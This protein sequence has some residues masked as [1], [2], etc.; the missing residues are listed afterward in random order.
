MTQRTA[1]TNP[2]TEKWYN[3]SMKRL[4][5][6]K[7]GVQDQLNLVYRD[8]FFFMREEGIKLSN[9]IQTLRSQGGISFPANFH[10]IPPID[11]KMMPDYKNYLEETKGTTKSEAWYSKHI[12]ELEGLK[13]DVQRLIQTLNRITQDERMTT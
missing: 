7:K 1:F 5:A 9:S 8:G 11:V 10:P 6:T 13:C 12:Y 2:K 4:E 3:D